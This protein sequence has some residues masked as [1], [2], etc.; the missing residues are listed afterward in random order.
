MFSKAVWS[1]QYHTFSQKVGSD[2]AEAGNGPGSYDIRET[3]WHVNCCNPETDN[4]WDIFN[5]ILG[6]QNSAT[7]GSVISY[8]VYWLFIILCVGCLLYEER[9]GSLPLKKEIVAALLKVPGLN[10][11]VRRKM[12]L[13]QE[14]A[15]DIVRQG[16]QELRGQHES[17][18][19]D[20]AVAHDVQVS[21]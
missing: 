4:G 20:K 9:T 19:M 14:H 6:W 3:V 16:E 5:A 17:K 2:V 12:A 15:D 18:Q 1:L 21:P 11:Y 7:Y 8:N 10:V 13:S